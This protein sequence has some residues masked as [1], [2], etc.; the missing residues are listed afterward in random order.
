MNSFLMTINLA[1]QPFRRERATNVL[2]LAVSTALICSLLVLSGLIWHQRVE[3]SDLRRDIAKKQATL[4]QLQKQQNGYSAILSK[5]QNADVFARSVF[6]NELIVRRGVS[7]TRVFDDI[8]KVLPYDVRLVTVRLPQVNAEETTGKSHVQLDMVVGTDKPASVL[9][10]MK[11]LQASDLFGSFELIA[12]QPPN[13]ND[14]LYRYA[15][16]VPYAQKL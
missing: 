12:S 5:P 10:F 6:L 16:R 4:S 11:R 8:T 7:W 2:L 1:S 14:P 13:Q 15:I 3:A 9:E